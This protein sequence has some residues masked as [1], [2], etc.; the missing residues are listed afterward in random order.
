M[1]DSQPPE[2]PS[3]AAPDQDITTSRQSGGVNAQGDVTAGR[4]IVGRD[5]VQ[6]TVDAS[7]QNIIHI[8]TP[9]RPGCYTQFGTF[10][11]F[12]V[13]FSMLF[14]IGTVGLLSSGVTGISLYPAS[15]PFPATPIVITPPT[16]CIRCTP[17]PWPQ[18][19]HPLLFSPFLTLIGMLGVLYGIGEV[20]VMIVVLRLSNRKK[21]KSMRDP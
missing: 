19:F 7:T 18:Y 11:K 1:P 2:S 12:S 5:V 14:A 21:A 9:T 8:E 4:D 15:T 17:T 20:V 3:S 10:A 16:P 13:V 6:T